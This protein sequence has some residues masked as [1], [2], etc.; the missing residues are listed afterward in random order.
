MLASNCPPMLMQE[1]DWQLNSI[2]YH[3]SCQMYFTVLVFGE[4]KGDIKLGAVCVW[5]ISPF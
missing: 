4:L 3:S 1:T 5:S 2:G